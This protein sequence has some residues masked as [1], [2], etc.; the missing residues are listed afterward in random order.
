MGCLTFLFKLINKFC[1]IR[2]STLNPRPS[3]LDPRL[4]P[5]A[6][7]PQR[8]TYN[9]FDLF[10]HSSWSPALSTI[11]P[12]H[13]IP[14]PGYQSSRKPMLEMGAPPL[15]PHLKLVQFPN[16]SF[17]TDF[18]FFWISRL[19]ALKQGRSHVVKSQMEGWS[20]FQRKKQEPEKKGG[21]LP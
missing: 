20:V 19:P 10:G 9:H 18:S 2:S 6:S 16:I 17:F 5:P 11:K 4:N 14:G 7:N 15:N 13:P 1:E 12:T 3:T 8:S 21:V